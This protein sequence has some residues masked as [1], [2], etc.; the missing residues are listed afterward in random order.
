MVARAQSP[1]TAN[2]AAKSRW[3]VPDP[4]LW[5]KLSFIEES[6]GSLPLDAIPSTHI[7]QAFKIKTHI[8]IEEEAFKYI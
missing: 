1:P 8:Q 7:K 4:N 6:G 5:M 2:G 3:L